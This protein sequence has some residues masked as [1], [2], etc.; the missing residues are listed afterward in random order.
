MA[1]NGGGPKDALRRSEERL[2]AFIE[3]A[4]DGIFVA[5]LDGRY[6]DV[7]KAGCQML[8]CTPE[9]IIGKT[10]MDF[11]R[12]DQVARLNEDKATLLRGD[13]CVGEW[14]L[15]RKDGTWLPV[16]VSAKILADG[17]WQGFVRDISGRRRIEH[18]QRFLAE[19]GA[20]LGRSLDYEETLI[21]VAQLVARD[22][23]DCCI[24]DLVQEDGRATRFTVVHRDPHKASLA[25]RL[26]KVRPGPPNFTR[27]ALDTG[28]PVLLTEV[29][30]DL[31]TSIAQSKEHLAALRELEIRSG[32]VA[33]MLARG[34][35]LGSLGLL[36]SHPKRRYDDHD[37][38][39][40][41]QVAHRAAF[42]LDNARLYEIARK[43]TAARDDMLGVVA[44]DLRN[45]IT[46]IH[47]AAEVMKLHP[48]DAAIVQQNAQFILR[49][50]DRAI[51]L[52]QD[53]IDVRSIEVGRFTVD[54][55]AVAPASAIG[56]AIEAVRPLAAAVEIELGLELGPYLPDVWADR[57]RL[58]QLFENLFGNALKFT[59]PGGTIT[60]GAAA[61]E[62][63]VQLW[64]RDTGKGIPSDELS[65]IFDRFWQARGT[66]RRGMGLGLAIVKGIVEAHG[67]Q[68][69]VESTVDV[70]TKVSFTLPTAADAVERVS[71][72][73]VTSCR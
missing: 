24:V 57:D 51:R 20:A 64:V 16:E 12:A 3:Q 53:L 54:C 13:Q 17:R 63:E 28:N 11:I 37:L 35:V 6:T 8:G 47:I 69:W 46:A 27:T 58:L 49:G 10:I 56:E 34:R 55:R 33:P 5:D 31:L 21:H 65:R 32:M 72:D 48:D 9:D 41:L 50:A 23:A 60:V 45:P 40:L 73:G 29:T 61:Q 38:D 42:A 44:H 36:S 19:V 7:N 4:S 39:F 68:I 62:G 15:R 59:L 30:P 66:K 2:R 14:E 71:D 52:I 26:E 70:G 43:A 18:E 1:A 67:G 25:R 22:L